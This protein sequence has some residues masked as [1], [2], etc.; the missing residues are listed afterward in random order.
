MKYLTARWLLTLLI[1][2]STAIANPG[3]D[4]VEWI[5]T[6]MTNHSD[7]VQAAQ[8]QHTSS[9]HLEEGAGSFPDP[10]IKL[11][12]F[13]SPIETRN[14]PQKAN[15]IITQLIPWPS[16]LGAEEALA[17][18]L[19]QLQQEQVKIL[20]LDL[21]F[22]AKA[23]I[24]QYAELAEK[25]RNKKKMMATLTNLSKV[26]LGRLKLGAANQAEIARINIEIA[27]LSQNIRQINAKM[28]SLQQQ[29][30]SMTG[31][32]KIAHLLPTTIDLRWG[33]MTSV[34]PSQID[35]SS[36]P[37]VRQAKTK[38][39][40]A[41]ARLNHAEA[42]RLPKLGAS[43]SWFQ[44]DESKS[45]MNNPDSGKDA[46][47]I[48]ASLSIP[49]WNSQYD[50]MAH[51]QKAKRSAAV[52]ELAQRELDLRA[53]IQSLY[54]EL[55]STSAISSMFTNDIL[56]LA[57]QA[58]KSDRDSYTQGNVP[59]ERVIENY[60]RVITFEDQLIESKVKQA[61]LKAALDKQLG[62]QHLKQSKGE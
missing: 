31:G 26:V 15:A 5:V 34:N 39:H 2:L 6:L 52:H 19:T 59:F 60:L 43:F 54:E 40:A 24:Y 17:A 29:I 51:S 23:M 21:T 56:P 46:W 14:G 62:N 48:G 55:K 53:G 42:K 3:K 9:K 18:S 25:R 33:Q 7:A 58:L 16:V 10:I 32:K 22:N 57:R 35:L 47:S 4:P 12:V 49:I 45:A 8:Q 41:Q 27:K 13:G 38:I 20:L 61:T 36:H 50:S 28:A 11:N 1:P 44:I 30:Q 37:L